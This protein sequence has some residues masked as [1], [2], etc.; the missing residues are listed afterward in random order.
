VSFLEKLRDEK[1]YGDLPALREAI[2]EDAA[3]ARAWFS[4]SG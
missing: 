3:R 4:E 2:E 1:K